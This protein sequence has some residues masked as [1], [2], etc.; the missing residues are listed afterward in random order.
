MNVEPRRFASKLLL[1]ASVGGLLLMALLAAFDGA[2]FLLD[3]DPRRQSEFFGVCLIVISAIPW[4]A[5]VAWL[6]WLA[7][8][9]SWLLI[10]PTKYPL[11][12][13]GSLV[14]LVA[15][16]ALWS[17]GWFYVDYFVA[18]SGPWRW[19]TVANHGILEI[20]RGHTNGTLSGLQWMVIPAEKYPKYREWF[21]Y[22]V[23]NPTG[24]VIGIPLWFCMIVLAGLSAISFRHRR[25]RSPGFCQKCGYDLRATPARCPECGTL[26]S[27]VPIRP[28]IRWH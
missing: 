19:L 3:P 20:G 21:F 7:I 10:R 15:V 4:I 18:G 25:T 28:P 6:S 13:L 14:L 22:F 12:A 8:K 27:S 1:P 5:F 24:W 26:A 16:S 2:C 11:M 9:L 17:R 23:R